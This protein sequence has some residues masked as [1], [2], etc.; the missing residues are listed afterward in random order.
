MPGECCCIKWECVC[1]AVLIIA[2]CLSL[3]FIYYWSEVRN[4]YNDFDW[5]SYESLGYW[6][7]WSVV[8]LAVAATLFTY[9]ALLLVLAVCLI[10]EGQQLYLHWSH[11]IGVLVVLAFCL[12][13]LAVLSQMWL[14][15]WSTVRL[16]FQVTA[17]YLHIGAV[18]AMVALSWPVAQHFPRMN[19]A[20][21]QGMILLLY[22]GVLLFLYLVPLGMYSP[23]IMEPKD[24]GPK[25]S[26]LGH[27]GVPMLAPENTQ[28]SFEKLIEHG[29]D[30]LETDVTLSYDGIP[31]LMHDSTLERTTDIKEVFP[32]RSN[33]NAAFFYWQELE[34]LNNGK[35]FVRDNPFGTKGMLSNE[36]QHTA[37]NQSIFKFSDFLR[38]AAN[39]NK[40]VIFD[41]YRPPKGHPYN[42]AYINRTLDVILNESSINPSL[43]LW[44]SGAQRSEVYERV[45]EF[46]QT[47]G[48]P[49][50]IEE[51][52]K[53]HIVKLNLPY[54][55]AT[56][57]DT[58]KYSDANIT[59]NLYVVSEPWL[60]S[61]AWCCGV[62]SVTTNAV[63]ILKDLKTPFFFMT[64][65]QYKLMWTLTDVVSAL[66]ILAVFAFHWWRERGFPCCLNSMQTTENG[67]YSK[68]RTEL[69]DVSSV[70]GETSSYRISSPTSP[71]LPTVCE[72]FESTD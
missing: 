44:L 20:V 17:P 71:E 4:D 9:I 28:M 31:F 46:Q 21:P 50:S 12:S 7:P 59:T 37:V 66:L 64:P 10:S 15:E 18:A 5:N 67:P 55:I 14:D 53:E 61:L 25:P 36:D 43:V 16:S 26:L 62:H 58:R 6:Y 34:Q 47:R 70:S 57:E 56:R 63:H 40:S 22:L 33:W 72:L 68:F 1:F 27:R 8:V 35:W 39:A 23:C 54:G 41:L 13:A 3:V 49:A 32:N 65:S 24:L 11:K 69:N 45:P 52:Q 42:E 48:S 60:F 38:L 19:K 30:G 29:G 51:L 2:F